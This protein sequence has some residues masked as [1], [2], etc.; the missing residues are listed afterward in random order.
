M[1]ELFSIAV[2]AVPGLVV[3]VVL[4]IYHMKSNN[5]KDVAF[6]RHLEKRDERL[7]IVL[8]TINDEAHS[9][10]D[11]ATAAINENTRVLGGV[12]RELEMSRREL[13]TMH[14]AYIRTT[15]AIEERMTRNGYRGTPAGE[16]DDKP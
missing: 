12:S 16:G 2:H 1:Q 4:M 11:R 6:L 3:V 13:Q 9:V 5:R 15:L 8:G 10:Q 14:D 7:A